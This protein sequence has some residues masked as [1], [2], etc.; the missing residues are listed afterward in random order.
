MAAALIAAPRPAP[1]P[2]AP[3][4]EATTAVPAAVLEALDYVRKTRLI[5]MY[6]RATVMLLAANFGYSE[7]ME[8]MVEHRHLYFLALAM[9]LTGAG[10]AGRDE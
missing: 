7:A 9:S 5:D 8:W 10:A 6:D 3:P 4:S 1:V 2:S